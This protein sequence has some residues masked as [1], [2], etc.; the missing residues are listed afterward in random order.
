MISSCLMVGCDKPGGGWPIPG[1]EDFEHQG[2]SQRSAPPVRPFHRD[3]ALTGRRT[4][5]R[6]PRAR[7]AASTR[8][9]ATALREYAV[10]TACETSDAPG[11]R[12]SRQGDATNA[13]AKR[14]PD[15]ARLVLAAL[16]VR[17]ITRK[18][19]RRSR[20][21]VK[22]GLLGLVA[23]RR[24]RDATPGECGRSRPPAA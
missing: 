7:A 11:R 6:Q 17:S 10:R 2:A 19:T 12:S 8:A 21:D 15:R 3:A 5:D 20:N 1:D 18:V 16:V 4:Q 13:A 24:A 9:R 23:P 22:R 14:P